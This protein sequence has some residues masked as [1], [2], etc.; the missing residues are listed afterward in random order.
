MTPKSP[1]PGMD[2]YLE[3][4]WRDVHHRLVTY[5]SDF[6]QEELPEALRARMEERV[7]VED[8]DGGLRG[9]YPDVRVFGRP[10]WRRTPDG[11]VAIAA[12]EED[13]DYGY[14]VRLKNVEP[15]AETYIEI[16][17][18][19]TS[20]RLITVI[21]FI[22]PTNKVPG[23]GRNQ[24]LG[25]QRDCRQGAV[26]LVEIDLTRRGNRGDVIPMD[27]L[28]E[29]MQ[30][31]A[32]LA[33]VRRATGPDEVSIYSMPLTHPLPKIPIPLRPADGE[34]ALDLQSLVEM[35]YRKG[36]YDDLDYLRDPNPPLSAGDAKW[37]DELLRKVG[38]RQ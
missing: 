38:K 19:G 29:H 15:L 16:L 31:A 2:P 9:I 26:N 23:D 35:A 34:I 5:T 4:H 3:A 33:S 13:I 1:F 11:A 7:L 36:R 27:D 30:Q 22:S 25:K 20:Y 14:V 12:A 32:Y 10:G 18:I 24:Y 37:A 28:P 21:E 6:L 8:E 17:E